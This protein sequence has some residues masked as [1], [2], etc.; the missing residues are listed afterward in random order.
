MLPASGG[1]IRGREGERE[2]KK[3]KEKEITSKI[4]LA[5]KQFICLCEQAKTPPTR[6]QARKYL[7]G[8]GTVLWEQIPQKNGSHLTLR[9]E[10]EKK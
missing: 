9:R 1:S 4:L 10:E 7:A 6:R 5:N 2:M 8:R 3:E